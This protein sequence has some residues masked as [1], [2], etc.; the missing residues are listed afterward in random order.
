MNLRISPVL[1]TGLFFRLPSNK[2]LS[3]KGDPCNYRKNSKEKVM[4]LLAYSANE[5]DKLPP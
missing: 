5:T 2:T 4:V 3:L 1:M